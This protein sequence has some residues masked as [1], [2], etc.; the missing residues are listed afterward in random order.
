M[1]TLENFDKEVFNEEYSELVAAEYD[2]LFGENWEVRARKRLDEA[3]DRAGKEGR[4]FD[5]FE[6][7]ALDDEVLCLTSEEYCF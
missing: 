6:E 4:D 5:L 1:T 3:C 7:F 2:G